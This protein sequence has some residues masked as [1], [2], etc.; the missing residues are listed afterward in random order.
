MSVDRKI[1]NTYCFVAVL[2]YNLVEHLN[3]ALMFDV[4]LFK[5]KFN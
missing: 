3:A 4:N 1:S 2:I 5:N